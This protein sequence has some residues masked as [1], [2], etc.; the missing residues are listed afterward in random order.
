[1]G[2]LLTA[3]G[4]FITS[5]VTSL[6]QGMSKKA[7]VLAFLGAYALLVAGFVLLFNGLMADL[8]NWYQPTGFVAAGLSL[9]P[10]NA[11]QCITAIGT[12]YLM[13]WAFLWKVKTAKAWLSS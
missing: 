4:T 1:M 6:F 8:M 12:A 2:V 10:S 13:R 3:I 9:V 7:L 11:N 5:I